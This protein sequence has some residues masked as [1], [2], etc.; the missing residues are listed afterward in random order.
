MKKSKFTLVEL[1]IVIAIIAILAAM[2]LP[3]L[4]KARELAKKTNCQNNFKTAGMGV[5]TYCNE[6]NDW[7]LPMHTGGAYAPYANRMWMQF[8]SDCNI[9]YPK[10]GFPSVAAMRR[11]MCPSMTVDFAGSNWGYYNWAFNAKITPFNDWTLIKKITRIKKTGQALCMTET[12]DGNGLYQYAYNFGSGN[13]PAAA[14]S[15]RINFRHAQNA[16][17]LFY[18]GHVKSLSIGDIPNDQ[19]SL[20][21]AFWKG[22]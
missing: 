9:V 4:N 16:N 22:N 5:L 20:V 3:A 11:Y 2:L 19:A 17:A 12:I 18:D 8:L 15:A 10:N 1:L 7:I 14:T 13:Q 6:Y 21:S